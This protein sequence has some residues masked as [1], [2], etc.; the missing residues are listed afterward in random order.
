MFVTPSGVTR[1]SQ[2]GIDRYRAQYPNQAAMGRLTL[3]ILEARPVWGMETDLQSNSVPGEI[4]GMTIAARW[5]LVHPGE[6]TA[7]GLT[8][9]V[10]RPRGDGWA[11]V[12]DA[13]I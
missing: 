7:T 1:G 2:G 6:A 4:Q 13:S 10:L 3:E 5:S 9:L 12:Q 8:L 11:I